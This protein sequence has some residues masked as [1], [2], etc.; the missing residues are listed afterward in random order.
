MFVGLYGGEILKLTRKIA[1]KRSEREK[2]ER[3]IEEEKRERERI[4]ERIKKL[5]EKIDIINDE[6]E[7]LGLISSKIE[8]ILD[9]MEK[10]RIHE[11]LDLVN[12]RKKLIVTNIIV[13]ISRGLGTVIGVSVVAALLIYILQQMISLPLIGDFIS[14]IVKLV[15][16]N[17][18]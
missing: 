14:E 2:L 12:N 8:A 16:D 15:Q 9:K 13:G 11:Y 1:E 3:R 5:N 4:E 10:N 17:L 6:K 7:Q 18:Q